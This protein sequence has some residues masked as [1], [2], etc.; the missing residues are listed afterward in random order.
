M[1]AT[2]LVNGNTREVSITPRYS[3]I[4]RTHLP[5]NILEIGNPVVQHVPNS[6]SLGIYATPKT[7]TMDATDASPR[8]QLCLET[9]AVENKILKWSPEILITPENYSITKK[10]LVP[11]I[12]PSGNYNEVY[13]SYFLVTKD[14]STKLILQKEDRLDLII[15]NEL[16]LPLSVSRDS[17]NK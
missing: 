17:T 15:H 13:L 7:S 3:V 2:I 1:I 5:L 9:N 6:R 11:Q 12:N 14:Y 16:S 4:N 10:L 8:V